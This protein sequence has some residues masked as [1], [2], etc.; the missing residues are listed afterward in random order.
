VAVNVARGS[1]IDER[2]FFEALRRKAISGAGIDV[3]CY[4]PADEASRERT[5]PAPLTFHELDNVL[6]SLH[7]AGGSRH[8]EKLRFQQLASLLNTLLS[9]ET[10]LH[11]VDLK[12]GF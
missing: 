10:A 3:W 7:R 11:R 6:M 1:I 2:P 12:E 5:K 9:G 4:Y 8:N